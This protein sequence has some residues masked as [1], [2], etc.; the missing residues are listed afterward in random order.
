V[1]KEEGFAVQTDAEGLEILA[2]HGAS[3]MT[4]ICSSLTAIG[5]LLVCADD[6]EIK[7]Q[8]IN[9]LGWLLVALGELGMDLVNAR[10]PFER[11]L[12]ELARNQERTR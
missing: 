1:S 5:D 7:D 3:A 10:N 2:N 12:R 4:A 6:K 9:D 11:N 8:S